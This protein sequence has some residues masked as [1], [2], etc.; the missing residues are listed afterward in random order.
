MSQTN[1]RQS[2]ELQRLNELSI[3]RGVTPQVNLDW[4]E[5]T[6]DEEF[7]SLY[8]AW[9]LFVGTGKDAQLD[10][11]ARAT[12]VK[13]QQINLMT[14]TGLLERHGISGIARLYDLEHSRPFSEYVGHFI[15][16]ETY[17]YMM[18][19][20]AI[21]AIQSNMPGHKPLPSRHV[22]FI[23]RWLFRFL[24]IMPGKKFRASA[25]VSVFRFA[26]RVTINA[27]TMVQSRI[28]RRQSLISQVWSFHALEE[29]RHLAFDAMVIE[30]YRLPSFVDWIPR[31]VVISNCIMLSVLLNANEIWAAR[32]LGIRVH[33]WQLPWLM[34]HT[35]APFKR[36]VF[37]LLREML[38][39]SP[40]R[41]DGVAM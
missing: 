7:L 21:E 6:S 18:L 14:F 22:D 35:K 12:F 25:T 15:K 37:G 3:T 10:A 32:Q 8:D 4:D 11:D 20:R 39:D 31:L 23:L 16:E 19:A 27:H 40:L 13:Y 41:D 28:K 24:N 9:S 26:E 5:S 2:S 1:D 34:R 17:H 33:Y 36:Q 29:A 38:F 30:N